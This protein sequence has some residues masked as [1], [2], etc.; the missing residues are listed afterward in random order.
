MFSNYVGSKKKYCC[1]AH[2]G[3]NECERIMSKS[4]LIQGKNI[5]FDF[6]FVFP[7]IYPTKSR[8]HP[9]RIVEQHIMTHGKNLSRS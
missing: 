7:Q 5:A 6:I 3:F 8:E 4:E 9:S 2:T 1:S